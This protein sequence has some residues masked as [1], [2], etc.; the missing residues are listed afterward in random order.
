MN[1]QG[2]EVAQFSKTE[3]VPVEQVGKNS[4]KEWNG[5][6]SGYNRIQQ[7][8]DLKVK[9]LLTIIIHKIVLVLIGGPQDQRKYKV[10]KRNKILGEGGRVYDRG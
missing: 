10:P 1:V 4:D 3:K 6:Q 7:H 5:E 2:V 8:A 9:C